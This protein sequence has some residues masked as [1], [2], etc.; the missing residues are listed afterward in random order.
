MGK[1]ANVEALDFK[2]IRLKTKN[3]DFILYFVLGT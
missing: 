3:L 2:I 1:C